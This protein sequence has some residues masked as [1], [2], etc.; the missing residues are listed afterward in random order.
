MTDQN[1]LILKTKLHR[2]PLPHVLVERTQLVEWLNQGID[3]PLT[4]VVG[5]AGY[6]KTTLIG[7]WLNRLA[8]GQGETPALPSAWLSLDENDS[9][10]IYFYSYFITALRTIFTEAC[11]ETLA[12]LQ[13]RQPAAPGCPLRHISE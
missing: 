7:T 3:S 11:A 9:D 4:L 2:P 5:P 8:T 1:Q 13:A 12:L 6:G 10:L